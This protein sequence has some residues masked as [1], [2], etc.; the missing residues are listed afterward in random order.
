MDKRVST[1]SGCSKLVTMRLPKPELHICMEM[2]G[3][4]TQAGGHTGTSRQDRRTEYQDRRQR[5]K[6]K[7]KPEPK[8]EAMYLRKTG[9]REHM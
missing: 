9:Y 4:R 6:H 7:T 5:T 8:S 2:D 3:P 1:G